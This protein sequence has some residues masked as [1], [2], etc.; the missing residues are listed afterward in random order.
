MHCHDVVPAGEDRKLAQADL[1]LRVIRPID[2]VEEDREE[3]VVLVE[4]CPLAGVDRVL[5]C[6]MMKAKFL[7]QQIEVIRRRRGNIDPDERGRV[8]EP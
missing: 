2:C 7:V 1:S 6:E 8:L 3:G 5:E 4:P